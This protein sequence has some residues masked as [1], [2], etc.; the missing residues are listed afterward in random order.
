MLKGRVKSAVNFIN[1]FERFVAR[2]TREHGCAGVVCGHIHVPAIRRVEGIDY[3]NCGDWV[4]HCTALVEHVD[5]RIEIVGPAGGTGRLQP[6]VGHRE[7]GPDAAA[8]PLTRH[9]G[10]AVARAGGEKAAVFPV[11]L[12]RRPAVR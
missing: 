10:A 5:G 7:S 6:N 11:A 2:Y 1:D 9:G 8:S 12:D 3:Y 4:E